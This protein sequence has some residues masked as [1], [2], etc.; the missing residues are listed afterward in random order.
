MRF[1]FSDRKQSRF[2]FVLYVRSFHS[3]AHEM[4]KCVA[5]QRETDFLIG[6]QLN[7]IERIR[8]GNRS[9]VVF[10]HFTFT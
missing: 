6:F 8:T 10:L 3:C 2:S 7:G 4:K 5:E 9:T 1:S